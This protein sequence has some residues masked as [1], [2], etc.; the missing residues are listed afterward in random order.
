MIKIQ[1]FYHKKDMTSL[2]FGEISCNF[3]KS[4]S[5]MSKD[6]GKLG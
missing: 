3:E 5:E 4:A 2:K 6:L 1:D